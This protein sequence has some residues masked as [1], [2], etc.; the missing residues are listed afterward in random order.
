MSKGKL[1]VVIVGTGYV[2]LTTGVGLAYLGHEVTCVDVNP[3]IIS[4]LQKGQATIYENGLAELMEAAFERLSFTTSLPEVLHGADVI[5]IAVGTPSKANGDAEISAIEKVAKTIGNNLKEGDSPVIVNKSTVP[6]GSCRR[7][8]TVIRKELERRNMQ[9]QF[10]VVSNP[11]FLREGV[12][13]G[14][15]LYPDRIVIGA[16]EAEAVNKLRQLY[17]PILE[18]TFTPPTCAPRPQGYEK[19]A[20][21][22][23]DP[24]SAELI[25]Y[26]ANAFLPM[27]ISFINEIAGLAE[28]VGAD[29]K[30]VVRGIGTDKRIGPHFLGAGIGW[31]GSCFGKD[32][33][34]ILATAKQYNVPLDLVETAIAVNYRQRLSAVEKLQGVLQNI[35]GCTIG[36]LGLAFKPGT[37]DLRDSPAIDIIERLL[38]FGAFVKVYDPV[39]M[40][41]FQKQYGNLPV[42]YADGVDGLGQGCDALLLVTDWPQ[43]VDINWKQVGA[44]MRRKVLIDGRN[45]FDRHELEQ[46]GF[47]YRGVG[48]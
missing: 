44:V 14:D 43:F 2:G 7:V 27:K 10:F 29:I 9:G 35:R 17:A 41:N 5:F 33:R 37:D 21:I 16:N 34:A 31:G 36:I 24:V 38:E 6:I 1:K 15:T 28:K 40:A 13:V 4:R 47:V 12:A 26:A 8:E 32:T 18:Q 25:K 48:R 45:M 30:E 20:F 3:D 23:T 39:A 46:A 19:P 11:E 42:E 22:V